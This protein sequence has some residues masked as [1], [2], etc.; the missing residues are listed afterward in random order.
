MTRYAWKITTDHLA[1]PGDKYS[2]VGVS[3]PSDAPD[4][5]LAAIDAGKGLTFRMYD[6][7]GELY[8]TGRAYA[9]GDDMSTEEFC[10]GPLDDY[11]MGGLGCTEIRWQGHP[12]M[13]VG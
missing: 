11:G 7:D 13:N 8:V 1:E 12:E 2:S 3:G 10:A 9:E 5:Y 4:E 6:D